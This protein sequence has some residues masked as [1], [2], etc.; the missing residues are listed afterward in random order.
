LFVVF[1]V[2]SA[3]KKSKIQI[4]NSLNEKTKD[5]KQGTSRWALQI[6]TLKE[7]NVLG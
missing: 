1:F 3:L 7:A 4:F 5:Q 2:T 6:E